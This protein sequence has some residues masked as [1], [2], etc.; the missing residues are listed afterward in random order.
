MKKQVACLSGIVM[1]TAMAISVSANAQSG[2]DPVAALAQELNLTQAQRSKMRDTFFQFLE[3]QDKVPL[4]GQV[5]MDNR[6]MLKEIITS[7]SFDEK[8][9]RAL[10]QKVTAVMENATVNRL[11]LRHDLYQ[12]LTPQQQKQYLEIVQKNVAQLLE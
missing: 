10:V 12:Q 9:A 1:A 5:V 4:P 3:K 8:K 6:G 2:Q 7:A 11:Q